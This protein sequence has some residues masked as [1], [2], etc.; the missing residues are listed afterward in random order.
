MT[1]TSKRLPE[2]AD[3]FYRDVPHMYSLVF[4]P[5]YQAVRISQIHNA[6]RAETWGEF[7]SLM[8]KSDFLELVTIQHHNNC[9]GLF[10]IPEPDEVFQPRTICPAYLEGD[11]PDWLQARQ[12]RWIPKEIL[13]QWGSL[14]ASVLNGPFWILDPQKEQQI[15]SELG[16][17]GIGAQRR[18]DLLFH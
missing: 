7:Q 14:E 9:D 11:Y 15:V 2:E 13:D 4:A 10:V 17:R 3:L 1:A 12:D 8:P 6:I 18:D 16:E 5:P